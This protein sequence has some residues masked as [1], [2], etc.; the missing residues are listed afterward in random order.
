MIQAINKMLAPLRTRIANMIA[1][2]VV[3]RVDDSKKIQIVQLSMGDEVHD[4][5]ERVQNYGFTSV[6]QE[7]AEAAVIFVRRGRDHG[8]DVAV[9]D[10]RNRVKGLQAGEVAVYSD[11]GDKIVM[12]RGGTIEITAAT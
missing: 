9:D 6:P 1:R 11:E 3:S 4:D 5:I 8:L 2:A 12:K 10:R 7:G